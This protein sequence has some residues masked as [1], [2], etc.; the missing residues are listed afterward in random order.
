R[1]AP[2]LRPVRRQQPPQHLLELL[3]VRPG[4]LHVL[5]RTP[6]LGGGD[7]LHRLRDV[8]DVLDAVNASLNIS[9]RLSR[10]RRSPPSSNPARLQLGPASLLRLRPR[11]AGR[12]TAP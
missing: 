9:H 4:P 12:R 8:L 3:S 5:L 7:Q 11:P 1:L 6:E 2:V 10:Q